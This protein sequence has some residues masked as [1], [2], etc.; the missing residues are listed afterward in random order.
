LGTVNNTISDMEY[1]NQVI[2]EG[3]NKVKG[4]IEKFS[5]DTE[6]QL[7]LLDVKIKVEGHIAHINHA[8]EAIHRNLNLII[9]SVLNSQ[10]GILQPQIVSPK[11][12]IETLQNSASRFPK[13]TMAPFT[14]SKDSS[15]LI[16][17]LCDVYIFNKW[18][19]KLHNKLTIG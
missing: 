10:K 14:R 1:N 8:M 6:N 19:I 3:L 15:H 2:K 12:I 11:L 18:N 17:K 9:E 13:D 16:L 5:T 4:Y 7:N